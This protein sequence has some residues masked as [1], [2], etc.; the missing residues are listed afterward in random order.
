MMQTLMML[1]SSLWRN[2][3]W[4]FAGDHI[5]LE[6][7]HNVKYKTHMFLVNF[8]YKFAWFLTFYAMVYTGMALGEQGRAFNVKDIDIPVNPS[9]DN[10][11]PTRYERFY[12]VDRPQKY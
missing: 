9:G 5:N 3:V 2:L 11:F 4:K 12:A 1:F 6:E 7:E 10:E 8:N